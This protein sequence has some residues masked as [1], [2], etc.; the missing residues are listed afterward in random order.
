[1]QPPND[2]I[3]L[4]NTNLFDLDQ[5]RNYFHFV[6]GSLRRRKKLAIA[7]FVSI[8]AVA[9]LAIATLPRS[10]HVEA[11][12]LAQR[13][14]VLA[15]RGDSPDA[16]T[17]PTRGAAETVLKRDNL[18][19]IIH[20]TDL[21]NHYRDH[22]AL[23]QRALNRVQG[24]FS[25]PE[26]DQEQLEDMVNLLGKKLNVW[27][28]DDTVSIAIDWP[29]AQ[30]AARIVD[31]AQRNFL[32]ARH[33]REITALVESIGI[34]QGHVKGLQSDVDEAV[35]ALE[36]LRGN[37]AGGAKPTASA[38]AATGESETHETASAKP[39]PEE[40]AAPAQSS[41]PELTELKASID[42]DQK[43]IDD[44]EGDRKHRLAD[45]QAKMT[46]LRAT[47]TENHPAVVQL[48]QTITALST[49]APQ[50]AAKRADLGTLQAEFAS[51][52]AERRDDSAP[53][54]TSSVT[55]APPQLPSEIMRLDSELR[56]DRDPTVVYARGHLRDAM[57]KYSAL[58][59]QIQTAQIDLETARAAFKYRYNVLTPAEVP[60]KPMKP[61]VL[62]VLLVALFAAIVSAVTIAVI[63]DVR[64]G[65]LVERWQL[66][67][68]LGSP[69]LGE[70]EIPRL[71]RRGPG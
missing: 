37:E 52:R 28:N 50:V 12:L 48:K 23:S 25:S 70:I 7:T 40:H 44:L 14:Q 32:D 20:E 3:E 21:I 41:G 46:E 24:M 6:S 60:R 63:A 10:Y 58:R 34:L 19:S 15:I 27:T 62:L 8:I 2:E 29:D 53:Y 54:V 65:V 42:A 39:P 17:A 43:A 56:D 11:K 71:L 67:T 9:V 64:S 1:M 59:A 30:M 13:S 26:N 47:L 22:R 33:A 66:E 5:V 55:T 57:E 61:N 36:N 18:V 69:I 31:I 51:K 35:K 38:A 4:G 16:S 45:A 49:P 68:I